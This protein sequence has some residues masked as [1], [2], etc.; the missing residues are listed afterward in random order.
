LNREKRKAGPS[1]IRKKLV[2][3]DRKNDANNCPAEIPELEQLLSD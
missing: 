1:G 2:Q 3:P